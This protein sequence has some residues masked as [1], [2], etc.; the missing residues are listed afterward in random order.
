MRKKLNQLAEEDNKKLLEDLCTWIEAN[1]EVT[2][3][4]ETLVEYT[5]LSSTDIQYLF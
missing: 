2:L 1:L 3:G 5:N 4:L